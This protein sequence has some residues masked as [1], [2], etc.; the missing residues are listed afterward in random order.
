M[1]SS[2]ISH[3]EILDQLLLSLVANQTE[4]SQLVAV[5][6]KK[7]Q[8]LSVKENELLH[9]KDV[10]HRM[11]K[12]IQS[13]KVKHTSLIETNKTLKNEIKKEKNEKNKIYL[14]VVSFENDLKSSIDRKCSTDNS[15]CDQLNALS[16]QFKSNREDFLL[17]LLGSEKNITSI[18]DVTS[19]SASVAAKDDAADKM[20]IAQ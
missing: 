17:S 19:S 7:K 10:T 4:Y 13:L 9:E 6:K 20:E 14:D 1:S 12:S 16:L 18:E 11:L 2:S 5:V 8:E 3:S 15:Y